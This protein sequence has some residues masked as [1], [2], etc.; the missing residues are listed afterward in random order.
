MKCVI[1]AA[2]LA[3]VSAC[4]ALPPAQDCYPGASPECRGLHRG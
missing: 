2:L 1:A 4:T 3:L